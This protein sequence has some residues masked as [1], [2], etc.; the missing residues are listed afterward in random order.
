[1]PKHDLLKEIR[2]VKNQLAYAKDIGLFFGAGTSCALS[3]PNIVSLTKNIEDELDVKSKPVYLIV[4][5]DVK[6]SIASPTI[7]NI[8]NKIRQIRAITEESDKKNI[9][10]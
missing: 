3:I 7:E 6:S 9:L 10:V 4:K 5:D 1:M 2:E 8:L